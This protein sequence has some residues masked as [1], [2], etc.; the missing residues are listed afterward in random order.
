MLATKHSASLIALPIAGGCISHLIYHAAKRLPWRRTATLLALSAALAGIVL[1][2]IYGFRYAES[3]TAAQQFKRPLELKIAD[4]ESL[5]FRAVLTL[6]SRFHLAPRPYIWGLADTMRAG[7][8]GRA[9]ET[10]VFG[11]IYETHPPPWVPLVLVTIKIPFG[12]IA[13]ALAGGLFLLLGKLPPTVRWPLLAFLAVGLFFLGFVCLKGVPYAG[14][15]HL[16]FVIPIIALFSGVALE[17]IFRGRSRLAWTFAIAALLAACVS[18]LP[19]R[20]IWGYHNLL[21]GG[22]ANAWKYFNNESVD[23]GQRSTELIAFYK[24]HVTENNAHIDYWVSEVVLK[25]AGIPSVDLDFDKPI[26][27][28]ISGWF[29]MQASSVAPYHRYD[30]AALREAT[31][32]ARFGTLMIFHG[33]FH[34]PGYVAGAMYWWAKQLNYL[35]PQDPVKS[36]AHFGHVVELEPHAF[37]ARIELGNFALKRRDVP[38][39]VSWYRSALEDAPP[40]FRS[41][42]AEQI[43]KLAATSPSS[44]PPLHNPEQE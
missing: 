14:V 35:N 10:H 39:A 33:T 12:T 23:L 37:T 41:N 28:D 42:I 15:R 36:E 11:R 26:S 7:L 27:S 19:Q 24:S 9:G 2:G 21:A 4:L 30:L 17:R 40:Q 34:L 31:P 13:L 43:A 3:G 8:E 18:A 44:V 16:L 22:S 38:S 5:H 32:V 1:W 20:R 25:S 6:L 29:F